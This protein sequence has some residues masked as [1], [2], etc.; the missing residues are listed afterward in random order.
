MNKC[1]GCSIYI[2]QGVCGVKDISLCR[3]CFQK[4]LVYTGCAAE[5]CDD[6]KCRSCYN[7]SFASGFVNQ[8]WGYTKNVVWPIDIDKNTTEKYWFKCHCRETHCQPSEY[9]VCDDCD[10]YYTPIYI[11]ASAVSAFCGRNRYQCFEH[12]FL[13]TICK[14]N[15]KMYKK[16]TNRD[17]TVTNYVSEVYDD[18]KRNNPEIVDAIVSS[19]TVLGDDVLNST[20]KKYIDS[21]TKEPVVEPTKKPVVEPTKKPVVEPTKEPVVEPTK[22]LIIKRPLTVADITKHVYMERGTIR[23]SD[24]VLLLG[25][26]FY[27]QAVR[28]C[29]IQTDNKIRYIDTGKFKIGGRVDVYLVDIETM[30]NVGVVEIKTRKTNAFGRKKLIQEKYDL[31]QLATYYA[32]T[33]LEQYY[34][35]EYA[36]GEITLHSFTPTEL[37]ARWQIISKRLDAAYQKIMSAANDPT[38][39]WVIDMVQQYTM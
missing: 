23:E 27:K 33:R 14:Y 16:I 34:L 25:E 15:P 38:Q 24:A 26:I 3:K 13:E 32:M 5:L 29:G 19:N 30:Q 10:Y 4:S 20:V 35:C 9:K 36:N 11:N 28:K 7:K 12:V 17:Q 37:E 39:K 1:N 31:D 22:E 6:E 8:Y 2:H 18:F 21:H